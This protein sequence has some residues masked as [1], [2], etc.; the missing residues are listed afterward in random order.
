MP[1]LLSWSAIALLLALW[2]LVVWAL[3]AV[4]WWTVS[5]ADALSGT[6]E[7]VS[8]LP[9]PSWLSP[10]VPPDLAPWVNEAMASLAPMV[11][12]L[13]QTVPALADGVTLAA[14]VVW[15]LGS[16]LLVLAGAGLN[17]FIALQRNRAGGSGF[18]A[19]SRWTRPHS[20][21]RS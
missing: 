2:S 7:R 4:T 14:W 6:A 13:L 15:G 19:L 8:Q 16:A 1:Y 10:W 5:N 20:S 3:H 11:E 12:R 21:S 18:N 9:V 17:V